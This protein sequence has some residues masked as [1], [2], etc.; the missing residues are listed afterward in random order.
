VFLIKAYTVGYTLDLVQ[1][2]GSTTGIGANVT[3]Y[4][5]PAILSGFYSPHPHSVVAYLRF[6]LGAGKPDGQ[7]SMNMP[8]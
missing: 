8:M 5:F 4:A 1:T 6:R 2:A 7:H 3:R